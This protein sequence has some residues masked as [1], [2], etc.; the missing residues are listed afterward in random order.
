MDSDGS[1]RTVCQNLKGKPQGKQ[2]VNP[3]VAGKDRGEQ[4]RNK[5]SAVWA[6]RVWKSATG[7]ATTVRKEGS[8]SKCK[9]AES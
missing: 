2:A 9:K 5:S 7:K 1:L 8:V 3:V 6:K 4:R